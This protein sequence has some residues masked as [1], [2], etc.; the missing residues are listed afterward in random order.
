MIPHDLHRPQPASPLSVGPVMGAGALVAGAT[1]AG[2][3]R[4][5][6]PR[7]LGWCRY[8]F[9]GRP[10]TAENYGR[11]LIAS[12]TLPGLQWRRQDLT[13]LVGGVAARLRATARL[14]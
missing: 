11:G 1:M 9:R 6:L 12:S 10:N 2:T 13:Q 3:L 14:K 4:S 5:V 7:F 8:V